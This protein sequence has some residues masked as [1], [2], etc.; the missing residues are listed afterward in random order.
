MEKYLKQIV[1]EIISI[2]DDLSSVKDDISS[3]KDDLGSVKNDLSSFKNDVKNEFGSVKKEIGSFRKEFKDFRDEVNNRF[4]T[5]ETDHGNRLATLEMMVSGIRDEHGGMLQAIIESKEVQRGEI[6]TLQNQSA[7][8]E[9][10]LKR[11][12]NM[13]LDDFKKAR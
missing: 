10:T 3:V 6:D 12:A 2:K 4:A 13:V 8:M 5:I 9:G 11:A 1:Q 7:L